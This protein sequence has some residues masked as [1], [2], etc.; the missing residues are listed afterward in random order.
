M[1][2]LCNIMVSFICASTCFKYPIKSYLKWLGFRVLAVAAFRAE[3]LPRRQLLAPVRILRTG[4]KGHP[5]GSGV[6]GHVEGL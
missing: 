5:A 2:I 3:R 4:A 6:G 1:K